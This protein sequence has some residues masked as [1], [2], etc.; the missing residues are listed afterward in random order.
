MLTYKKIFYSHSIV[1]P[2][3][4]HLTDPSFSEQILHSSAPVLV[5]FG[6]PWCGLCKLIQPVLSQYAHSWNGRIRL[7]NINADENFRLAST[8][9]LTNLPTL[10]LIVD[11]RV[12]ERLENFQSRED[13]R[14]MLDHIG[15]IDWLDNNGL[16]SVLQAMV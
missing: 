10:I 4:H 8:Y 3:I 14:L 7:V 6:A 16:E 9:R 2:M 11:G 13:L 1:S 12:V 5:N 15:S